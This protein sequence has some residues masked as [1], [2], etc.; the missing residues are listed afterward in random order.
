MRLI[1][2]LRIDPKDQTWTIAT[3]ILWGCLEVSVGVV[4][5]CIPALMPLFLL[6]AG[7]RRDSE[8]REPY[9]RY[10]DE[11]SHSKRSN[12]FNRMLDLGS[13]AP[14]P[15]GLALSTIKSSAPNDNDDVGLVRDRSH[16]GNIL[17]TNRIVQV[18]QP[19]DREA[20]GS[21]RTAHEGIAQPLERRVRPPP[22][23]HVAP[24]GFKS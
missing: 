10:G 9:V 22:P 16:T 14:L 2:V 6:L 5:T 15:E 8:R 23:A 4:S 17:V 19:T 18:S 13:L 24:Q 21:Q 1:L 3:P 12:G 20:D 11:H 7:K